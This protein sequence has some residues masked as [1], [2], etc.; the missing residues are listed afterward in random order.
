MPTVFRRAKMRE[1]MRTMVA[2]N[3]LGEIIIEISSLSE[4]VDQRFTALRLLMDEREP[5]LRRTRR[6]TR[7]WKSDCKAL[8]AER[9]PDEY[10]LLA[11]QR[12]TNPEGRN[13]A[14]QAYNDRSNEFRAALDDAQKQMLTR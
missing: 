10:H 2:D 8:T 11:A 12:K 7:A 13:G 6:G 5:A 9:A 4:Q 3:Q 14:S 1:H